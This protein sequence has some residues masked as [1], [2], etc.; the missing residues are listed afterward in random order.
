MLS[1]TNRPLTRSTRPLLPPID[2]SPESLE[3]YRQVCVSL[4]LPS[5][6]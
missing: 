1:R 5:D 2:G 6:V 4:S 3:V